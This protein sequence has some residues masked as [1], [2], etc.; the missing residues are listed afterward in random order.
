MPLTPLSLIRDPNTEVKL[1]N[2]PPTVFCM[3]VL[4]V[5]TGYMTVLM[6]APRHAPDT[7]S[8]SSPDSSRAF[9][10]ELRR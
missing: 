4:V 10:S 9:G 5:L 1:W 3:C 6:N 7:K 2:L 8:A